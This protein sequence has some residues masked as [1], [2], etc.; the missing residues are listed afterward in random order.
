MI[1]LRAFLLWIVALIV[2]IALIFFGSE[3]KEEITPP[4]PEKKTV[5]QRKIGVSKEFFLLKK[6]EPLRAAR[7]RAPEASLQIDGS[8]LQEL[9][10]TA[11]CLVQEKLFYGSEGEK[12]QLFCWKGKGLLMD[13]R[14]MTFTASDLEMVLG[15]AP[16]HILPEELSEEESFAVKLYAKDVAA[17]IIT[18]KL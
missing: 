2:A 18:G 12:Q 14:T 7:L 8:H 4:S 1:F 9:L 13:Y 15:A 3:S 10:P 5:T 6:G 11:S 16:G 17:H